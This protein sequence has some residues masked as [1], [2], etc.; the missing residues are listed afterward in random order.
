MSEMNVKDQSFL[1]ANPAKFNVNAWH[2]YQNDWG[3]EGGWMFYVFMLIVPAIL[4]GILGYFFVW[5]WILML[6]VLLFAWRVHSRNRQHFREGNVCP[7]KVV[8]VSPDLV[9]VSTDLA[10]DSKH[11]YPIIEVISC[12]FRLWSG[13]PV[14][15][16]DRVAVVTSYDLGLDDE[17]VEGRFKGVMAANPVPMATTDGQVIQRTLASIPIEGWESL[18]H[19]LSLVPR[20]IQPG[21]YSYTEASHG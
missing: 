9:A 4:T 14:Q 16:G 6:L 1:A 19:G 2:Y 8:S 21:T 5:A 10:H 18:E 17:Q 11:S 12:N 20:P 13:D 7:G 15:I 3:N